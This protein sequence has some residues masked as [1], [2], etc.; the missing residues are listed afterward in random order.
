MKVGKR[1]FISNT[2]MVLSTLLVLLAIG[3][4][5]IWANQVEFNKN[6]Q[7]DG[8]I[9]RVKSVL[10]QQ[11]GAVPDW[12]AL[13]AALADYDYQLYVEQGNTLVYSNVKYPKIASYL[14][15]LQLSADQTSVFYEDGVTAIGTLISIG[16]EA[17][18]VSAT[19]SSIHTQWFG[20]DRSRFDS[21]LITFLLVGL[22][23]IAVLL[24]ISQLFTTRL[25]RR[26]MTPINKLTESAKRIEEGD[27]S[28]PIVYAGEDEFESVCTSFNQMQAHLRNE[29]GK[30]S[31]Y[32]K[33]RTD[34][35]SGISHDLRTPLT[36]VKG[37]IKG[38][39]DG[40][41][42]TQEKQKEYLSIAYN[43][44]CDMDVLLQRLFYFS[45][46]ETGN[47]P[48]FP[49]DT[50]MGKF[51]EKYAL[52]IQDDLKQKNASIMFEKSDGS[53]WVRI[54][55]EQMR[56]VL[57][58]LVENALR[59]AGAE[60]LKLSLTVTQANENV[61]LRFADNGNGVSPEKL[62][63]LFEQFY[64]GDESRNTK[65]SDGTGLGLYIVKYIIEAQGG[66]V[67]VENDQGLK[68]TI[69]LP[70]VKGGRT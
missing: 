68:F 15:K 16:D 20:A 19:T 13:S 22:A 32:E 33:A 29:Q 31:T 2:L 18:L 38:L 24:F 59:Y 53:H 44:A 8:N 39:Q 58:N 67:V 56:Q 55:T 1:L 23:A 62:P 66:T 40:I 17:Y 21:F 14:Q 10:E 5:T 69:T 28:T 52:D 61:V 3:G 60:S 25:V 64:R 49:I 37:Y 30:N 9:F 12:T 35:I 6:T 41:A 4:G 63:H 11:Q 51:A 50:D 70:S 46:L 57:A 45:K 54:D 27:L 7:L 47:L 36:S 48:F 34:M 65:N 43:K 26:I 42:N